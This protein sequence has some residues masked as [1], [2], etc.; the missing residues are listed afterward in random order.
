MNLKD[1]KKKKKECKKENPLWFWF[2]I[3]SINEILC[4]LKHRFYNFFPSQKRPK[5]TPWWW[6]AHLFPR[7]WF[8]S[9]MAHTKELG[10][11]R[12]ADSSPETLHSKAEITCVRKGPNVN[13]V[14]EK[15]QQRTHLEGVS[16]WKIW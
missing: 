5:R 10:L 3:A 4:L 15:K 9:L 13:E 11:R 1:C 12:L 14:T 2:W 16:M 7:S 8:L 6:L